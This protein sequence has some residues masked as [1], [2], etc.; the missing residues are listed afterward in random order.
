MSAALLVLT[1]SVPTVFAGG[2]TMQ[3]SLN[4]Y[5]L[6]SFTNVKNVTAGDF[7]FESNLVGVEVSL[8]SIFFKKMGT[9]PITMVQ[10]P[11]LVEITE[12]YGVGEEK[13][14]YGTIDTKRNGILFKM[15]DL[16]ILKQDSNQAWKAFRLE[17]DIAPE[18]NEE[19]NNRKRTPQRKWISFGI[20]G[21][22]SIK[23]VATNFEQSTETILQSNQIWLCHKG[24]H[25]NAIKPTKVIV[26]PES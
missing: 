26:A 18:M 16:T 19:M 23:A 14:F 10:N 13:I 22:Y 20:R 6:Y 15:E 25:C 3:V 11:R 2:S 12:G 8:K 1:I 5:N 24:N 17:F 21:A 7:T 4:G 9:L